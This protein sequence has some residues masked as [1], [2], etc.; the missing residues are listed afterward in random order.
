VAGALT[1]RRNCASIVLVPKVI[2][3]SGNASSATSEYRDA[4][5]AVGPRAMRNGVARTSGRCD[6]ASSFKRGQKVLRISARNAARFFP[7]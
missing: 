3:Q 4:A 2:R 1:C 5:F 7:K 6:G